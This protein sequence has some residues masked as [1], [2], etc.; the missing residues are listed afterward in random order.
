MPS[1][2]NDADISYN[3]EQ[4]YQQP[5]HIETTYKTKNNYN[6]LEQHQ[7][8]QQ[9][10]YQQYQYNNKKY[11]QHQQSQQQ[12]NYFNSINQQSSGMESSNYANN[13]QHHGNIDGSYYYKVENFSSFGTISCNAEN[14]YGQSGPCL[15]HIMVAGKNT[16]DIFHD[17]T[18]QTS[19]KQNLKCLKM[20]L[21]NQVNNFRANFPT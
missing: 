17:P 9:R 5:Q 14:Q 10:P 3:N 15:Y 4:H 11:Q 8:Q 13:Q 16:I 1:Y 6:S 18:K 21:K 7:Q 12:I 20:K 2:T 19:N